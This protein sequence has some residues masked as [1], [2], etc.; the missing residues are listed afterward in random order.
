LLAAFGIPPELGAGVLIS[1]DKLDKAA[2]GE[3][4]AELTEDRGLQTEQAADLVGVL[5]AHD[6]VAQVRVALTKTDVGSAGLDEVDAVLSLLDGQIP[7]ERI[8]FTPRLARGL[9]YYTGPIWELI[10]AGVAGSLGGGG[11]YD[12][13]I[14]QLGGPD[15]PGTGSSLGIDRI[16]TLM[17]GATT[18]APARLDVAVTMLGPDLAAQSFGFAVAGRSAGLRASVYLGS[19]AKL[20]TQL[21]WANDSGS[22]WC[23]IY[24]QQEA[25]AGLATVRDMR[26]GHQAQVAAGDLAGYLTTAARADG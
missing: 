12:H 22:R 17:L 26:T 25:Q 5:T 19:S 4:V 3:V 2:P 10:A 6:A 9:S 20:R 13:L 1:L 24:G 18:G 23:V 8:A 21:K 11:R 16:L 7:A 14:A 15:V